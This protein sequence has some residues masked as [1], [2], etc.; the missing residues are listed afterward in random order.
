DLELSGLQELAVLG[1]DADLLPF[2]TLFENSDPM[3]PL[4]AAVKLVP[5]GADPF[6]GPVRQGIRVLQ[7][8]S[9]TTALPKPPG[10]EFLGGKGQPDRLA[11]QRN[12]RVPDQAIES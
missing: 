12:G 9:R 8:T 10:T 11:G 7:H 1:R 3:G 5:V 2:D 4:Q 6:S